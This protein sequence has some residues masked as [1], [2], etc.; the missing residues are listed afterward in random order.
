MLS[1]KMTQKGDDIGSIVK[2]VE[3]FGDNLSLYVEKVALIARGVIFERLEVY[4]GTSAAH[5]DVSIRPIGI[6]GYSI[7]V[8]P[9]DEVG[10]FVIDG[11]QPHTISSDQPMPLGNGQF[12]T[13]VHHPG[14]EGKRELI[15]RAV[16][17][18]LII[19]LEIS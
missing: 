15:E 17:E 2:K 6:L 1:V 16:R 11:V 7:M 3:Q 9:S 8:G 5:L 19:A 13:V 18:S 10:N 14:Y 4:L 12:A